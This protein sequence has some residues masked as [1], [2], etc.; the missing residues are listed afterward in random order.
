MVNSES[1]VLP[2]TSAV[3]TEGVVNEE[4]GGELL[5]DVDALLQARAS[6]PSRDDGWLDSDHYF[7]QDLPSDS[8]KDGERKERYKDLD[9]IQVNGAIGR[10][11]KK[12]KLEI[13]E[14]MNRC[15]VVLG[16]DELFREDFVEY[17]HGPNSRLF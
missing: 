4:Q 12:G 8:F 17:F 9:E 11:W 14:I 16:K 2:A 10:Q 13:E 6:R 1:E 5:E 15:T 3:P 7:E